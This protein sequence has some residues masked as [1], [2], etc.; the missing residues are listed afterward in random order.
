MGL[1]FEQFA[2]NSNQKNDIDDFDFGGVNNNKLEEGKEDEFNF[3]FDGA[4]PSKT[5][6]QPNKQKSD[7]INLFDDLGAGPSQP[8]Q[9]NN[10]N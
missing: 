9:N 1:N 8:N 10:N 4:A 6:L 3:N 2:S 7:L 5:D